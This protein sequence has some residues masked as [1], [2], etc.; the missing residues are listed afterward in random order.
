MD[1][2]V[3]RT[4]LVSGPLASACAADLAAAQDQAVADLFNATT[5]AGAGT[6]RVASLSR[7]DFLL[8]I[9]PVYLVLP[10]LSDAIQRKW[11]RILLILTGSDRVDLTDGR[12]AALLASAV[13]DG[14]LTQAQ[15]DGI[16][17]RAC[18]RGETLYGAGAVVTAQNIADVRR[19]NGDTR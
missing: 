1:L 8:A 11:D 10:S 3:L 9:S 19:I 15:S 12:V 5:G 6:L 7:N 2:S 18:S 17:V 4:D 13:T 16:G 14:V